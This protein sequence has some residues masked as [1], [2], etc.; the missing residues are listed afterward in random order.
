MFETMAEFVLSEHIWEHSFE[1]PLDYQ[2]K[3]RLFDRRPYATRDGYLCVMA[4]TD[5][6]F[7]AFC[8]VIGRAE[9][10][11]DPRFAKRPQRARHLKEVYAI[12]EEALRSRTSAEWLPLLEQADIPAAPLHTLE[13]L[14]ADPHLDDVGFFEIRAHPTEGLL[15]QMRLPLRFFGSATDNPRHCPRLGEHSIEVLREAGLSDAEIRAL[16]E[17]GVVVANAPPAAAMDQDASRGG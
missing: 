13:S 7:H 12:T 2:G 11:A 14:L 3:I 16:V 1:P 5:R 9:L 8:D 6:Q 15:R 17:A 4:S 10:K